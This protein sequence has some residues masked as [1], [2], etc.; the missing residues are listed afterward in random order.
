MLSDIKAGP[1]KVNDTR[2]TY[3]AVQDSKQIVS[4]QNM[5]T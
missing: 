2:V 4:E 5:L 1:R 3:V